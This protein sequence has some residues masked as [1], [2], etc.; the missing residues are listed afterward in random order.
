M[1]LHEKAEQAQ[2]LLAET[3]LDCWLTF[4]RESK[5]HPDPGIDLVVGAAVA[6]DSAF[7]FDKSGARIAIIGRYDAPNI[8]ASGV[9]DEVIGYD[10]GIAGPL[11]DALQRL[12]PQQIGLNYS[13]D[14]YTADGL[15]HGMWLLLN[16]LLRG[17]HY[18]DWLTS[19]APLLGALR[20]RKSP[21][22]IER[23]R[24]AVGITE[25]IIALTTAQIRPGVSEAQIAAFV[26]QQF[27]D[28]GVPSAWEPD[29]CPVVNSGPESEVGHVRPQPG[30]LVAPGHMVHMDL[31]VVYDGY[32]SDL[33]R[34]WY[35]TRPGETAPPEHIRHAFATVVRAIE[36]G[37]SLLKPGVQGFVV[38]AAARQVIVEAG[39]P[40][41]KH[42]LGHSLGR[43]VHDGGT[44]LGPRWPRYGSTPEG[45]VEAGNVF[46][47]ELG[48]ATG[49]GFIGLEE[50]VVVTERGC[51]FL[52]SFQRELMLI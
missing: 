10:E 6:W 50:D 21:A 22:E 16:N 47:L 41:Y 28:R 30:I 23:I 11:L 14:D 20:G 7:L 25:A 43:A 29:Y 24:E 15:T 46:T 5:I 44:L 51:E 49:A 45:R 42:A 35:V 34:M 2:A 31:G 38:D 26:H 48:V 9:F 12:D 19:A 13:L 39:Y 27:R 32:C 36:A 3:G 4:V 52:S 40:E 33:Q 17:S 1:L 37:A 18:A 8:R